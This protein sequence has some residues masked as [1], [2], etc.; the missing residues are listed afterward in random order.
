MFVDLYVRCLVLLDNGIVM[1]Q[2][3]DDDPLNQTGRFWV[4]PGGAVEPGES[5]FAAAEREMRE[6]TGL[7]VRATEVLHLR[8]WE[9]YAE[10]AP[11]SWGKPGRGLEVYAGAE[12]LGGILI[13]GHDPELSSHNQ[14]LCDVAVLSPE[15][16]QQVLYYPDYLLALLNGP[17]TPQFLGLDYFKQWTRVGKT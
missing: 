14:V 6:E 2:H 15:R 3:A 16:L 7:V 8:E 1:V 13:R 10:N 12:L 5:L 4:L 11:R 17:R 9:W